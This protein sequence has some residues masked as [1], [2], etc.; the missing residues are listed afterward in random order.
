MPRSANPTAP[1][2]KRSVMARK[3]AAILRIW[4]QVVLHAIFR[5]C[6]NIGTMR[7]IVPPSPFAALPP[8]PRFPKAAPRPAHPHGDSPTWL[9]RLPVGLPQPPPICQRF[10]KFVKGLVGPRGSPWTEEE[11]RDPN[12]LCSPLVTSTRRFVRAET[13]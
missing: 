4:T 12:L 6:S 11:R 13:G 2:E 8:F 5:L 3:A 1:S 10:I 7:K 9:H